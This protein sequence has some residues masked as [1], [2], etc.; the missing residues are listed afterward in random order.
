MAREEVFFI[1]E[2][3]P[4]KKKNRKNRSEISASVLSFILSKG[5][6]KEPSARS[7]V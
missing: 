5:P 6:E 1:L 4:N 7:C 3:A 2:A